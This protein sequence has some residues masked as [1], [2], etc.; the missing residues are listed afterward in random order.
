MHGKYVKIQ[1]ELLMYLDKSPARH[2]DPRAGLLFLT[3]H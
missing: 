1:S 3:F 2:K